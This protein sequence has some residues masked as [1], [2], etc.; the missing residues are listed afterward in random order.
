[1]P[2]Q[3]GGA[4]LRAIDSSFTISTKTIN[5]ANATVLGAGAG[6]FTGLAS[7]VSANVITRRAKATVRRAVGATFSQ[8]GFT[9]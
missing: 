4:I 1:L 9:S 6:T 7:V 2:N 5:T 3:I 8:P